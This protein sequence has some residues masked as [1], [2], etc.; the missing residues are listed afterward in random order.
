LT[1][2]HVA[3]ATATSFVTEA[4]LSYDAAIYPRAIAKPVPHTERPRR[5]SGWLLIGSPT[6]ADDA[7]G[8]AG[9]EPWRPGA[10]FAMIA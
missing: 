4:R 9:K 1:R 6:L 7:R 5:K 8:L 2:R 3:A 10:F